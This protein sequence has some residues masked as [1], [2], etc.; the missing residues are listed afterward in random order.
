MASF[1][2]EREEKMKAIG[3]R[4]TFLFFL[5]LILSGFFVAPFG[6]L[7]QKIKI[8]TE[9][10]IPVVYN[11]KKPAPPPGTKTNLILEEELCI[12]DEEEEYLFAEESAYVSMAVDGD[13]NIY[14]VDPKL[15][16]IR[17]FSLEGKLLK[18]F[19]KKGQGPEEMIR[20]FNIR[21]TA[22]NE[23]MF[24]D[25]GNRR[26][27]FY[28]LDGEF[29]RFIPLL[30]WSV[31][32]TK[33][34]SKGNV[35]A[36]ISR[37]YEDDKKQRKFVYEITRFNQEMEPVFTFISID[38]TN[39]F[40]KR[41]YKY[42][43]ERYWQITKEDN[44]IMGY[45]E[46]YEL[47]VISSDGEIIRKIKKEYNPVK[48]TKEEED[49]VSPRVKSMFTLATH[50]LGFD[51]YT[52]D[53]DGRIFAR[54]WERTKDGEGRFYDVFD[55]EGRYIAKFATTAFIKLWIK[56]KL[57]TAEETEDGFHVIKRYNV[58]WK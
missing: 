3:S 36:D 58:V 51:Y 29:L 19:G 24:T 28:S 20:P 15:V 21:V 33:I 53:E 55:S 2:N 27:T 54:T 56:G 22:Q 47:H 9:N 50:H 16:E 6:L 4:K 26:I 49:N 30:K 32:R 13:G 52:V 39:E 35:V 12:G 23:L 11:P 45:A 40:N 38:R 41:I 5:L 25:R 44:I 10:G 18:I 34:D 57:Y 42:Q 46:D 48:V 31:G 43:S 7:A 37:V 17:K 8:K 1:P 14:S